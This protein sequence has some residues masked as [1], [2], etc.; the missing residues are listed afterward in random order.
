[1]RKNSICI[2]Y[3]GDLNA[4]TGVSTVIKNLCTGFE[5]YKGTTIRVVSSREEDYAASKNENKDGVNSDI[6]KKDHKNTFRT[7]FRR[8]FQFFN[9]RI[10]ISNFLYAWLSYDK[11][12]IKVGKKAYRVANE[13]DILFFHD[14]FTP[15]YFRKFY[16]NLWVKKA[17]VIVLHNDGEPLKMFWEY[18]PRLK[19]NK[20]FRKRYLNIVKTVIDECD[21]II[22]LS[23]FAL[24]NFLHRFP[25]Y[26]EK[27]AVISNGIYNNHHK[28]EHQ[29]SN[30]Q[31]NVLTVGTVSFRKGHDLI[32]DALSQM[33]EYQ[34]KLF[35]FTWVGDGTILPSLKEKSKKLKLTNINFA[36]SQSDV[37]EFLKHADLFLL[38]SR[39][40][41]LPMAII[42]ALGYGLPIISTN[43]GGIPEL[44]KNNFNGWLINPSSGDLANALIDAARR[45]DEMQVFGTNSKR[46]FIEKYSLETMVD[47]YDLVFEKVLTK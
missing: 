38:P 8:L 45:R 4:L 34:R 32:I 6:Q 16:L 17:K 27:A 19:N 41:G 18:F 30:N 43:V 15:Y 25:Q 13:S 22:L 36:G 5:Q 24:K 39:N 42:E 46:I 20:Y 3:F 44:V 37:R 2:L 10:T 47:K 9:K 29:F 31:I 21:S 33:E 12:A 40:E 11:N 14:L 7:T 35:N 23:D 26:A 28:I 1:M